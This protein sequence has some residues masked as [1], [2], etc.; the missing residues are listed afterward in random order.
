MRGAEMRK[1]RA[2][3]A[4]TYRTAERR[5][6]SAAPRPLSTPNRPERR[7]FAF[8]T[9]TAIVCAIGPAIAALLATKL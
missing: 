1:V 3:Q 5:R 4:R 8:V 9:L 6:V 2:A 7:L